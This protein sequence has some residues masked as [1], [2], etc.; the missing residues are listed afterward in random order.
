MTHVAFFGDGERPFALPLNE[1]RQLERATGHGIGRL[2]KIVFAREFAIADLTET[3]RWALIGGGASPKEA[4][5]LI[6][7]YADNR[8]I[9]E[10]LTVVVPILESAFF[11]DTQADPANDETA[12]G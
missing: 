3:I 5:D 6:A 7:A 4:A 2:C 1:T 10:L 9:A 12:N 11:G 8:P